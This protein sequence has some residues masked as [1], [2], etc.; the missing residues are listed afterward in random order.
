M[1]NRYIA[2]LSSVL[3]A[4]SS[5]AAQGGRLTQGP[6][7]HDGHWWLLLTSEEQAGYI[8]GDSDCYVWELHRKF[9]NSQSAE[10]VNELVTDFYRDAPAKRSLPVFDAIRAVDLLPPLRKPAPGGEVWKDRHWY[11]DGQWWRQGTPA[12]RL[13]FVE[14]YLACYR[15][16][17]KNARSNF[18]EPASQ[19]VA[20][21]N[22]WYGLNEETGDVIPSRVHAKIAHV[23]FKFRRV[24]KPSR[25]P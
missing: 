4:V 12:D 24:A 14:G 17:V 10:D 21:I 25:E 18:L 19:Y 15:A 6:R 11:F 5:V 23:L 22:Q 13:G 20:L 1:V 7:K 16:G 8:N 9:N 2:V 3:L